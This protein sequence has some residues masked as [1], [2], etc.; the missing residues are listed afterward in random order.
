[1]DSQRFA[2]KHSDLVSGLEKKKKKVYESESFK[3][4]LVYF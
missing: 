2:I 4:G 1:M 3:L